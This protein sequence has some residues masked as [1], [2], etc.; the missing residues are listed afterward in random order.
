MNAARAAAQNARIL[1]A[2]LFPGLDSRREAASTP[3]GRHAAMAAATLSGPKPPATTKG[4][5]ARRART[6]SKVVP[7][8][9][10]L[11]GS[12]ASRSKTCPHE[13]ANAP[14]RRARRAFHQADSLGRERL[15]HVRRR[16]LKHLNEIGAQ[17]KGRGQRERGT[18]KVKEN[19][20]QP[21]PPGVLEEGRSASR[22][23]ALGLPGH[24]LIPACVTPAEAQVSRSARERTPQT[25]IH[26]RSQ[27][28]RLAERSRERLH[29]TQFGMQR[30]QEVL[31]EA[32]PDR[33]SA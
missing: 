13:S 15:A 23:T 32:L 18:G 10:H 1:S 28:G 12:G 8:P 9:P 14:K 33:G 22:G 4:R 30:A 21:Q 25:L 11:P 20:R 6:Q 3:S 24:V 27:E 7:V 2:S 5:G 31:E 26:G 16:H 29:R 17:A 19:G